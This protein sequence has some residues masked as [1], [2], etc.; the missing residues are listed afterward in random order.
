MFRCC[1]ICTETSTLPRGPW[2]SQEAKS[3]TVGNRIEFVSVADLTNQEIAHIEISVQCH[4]NE[5]FKSYREASLGLSTWLQFQTFW[6]SL[7]W[8]FLNLCNVSDGFPRRMFRPSADC[9]QFLFRGP[10]DLMWCNL[11]TVIFETAA[12]GN[13]R[14]N[15]LLLHIP[16]LQGHF[17]HRHLTGPI[18]VSP[19][20]SHL[21]F[22]HKR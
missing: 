9:I 3:T 12:S 2:A 20:I 1:K 22:R 8:H 16:F 21:T 17:S 13:L 15:L 11:F 4:L 14:Q 10:N 7:C 18:I 19:G 6:G 5:S